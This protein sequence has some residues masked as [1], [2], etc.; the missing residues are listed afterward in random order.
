MGEGE[1][2]KFYEFI[3]GI[4]DPAGNFVGDEKNV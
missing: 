1:N 2:V 3:F 4:G